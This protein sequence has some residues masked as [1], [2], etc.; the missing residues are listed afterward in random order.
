VNE[1]IY[2]F[3]K[4]GEVV[5]FDESFKEIK[6][7]KFPYAVFASVFTNKK[8]YAVEKEGYLIEIESDLSSSKVIEL[9]DEIDNSVFGA[10]D[11]IYFNKHTITIK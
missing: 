9:P 8:L 4:N 1:K 5:M 10:N 11:K 6:K 2:I 3:T 7:I